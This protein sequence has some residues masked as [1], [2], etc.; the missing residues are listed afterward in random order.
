M[1]RAF[2]ALGAAFGVTAC[3]YPAKV[4]PTASGASCDEVVA[5]FE[6]TLWRPALSQCV[7]CHRAGGL[8]ADSDLVLV[9][10]SEPGAM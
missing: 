6:D 5:S 3:D 4:P 10:D 1:R 8:A 7:T 9:T 2:L